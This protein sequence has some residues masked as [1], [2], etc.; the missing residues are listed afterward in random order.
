VIHVIEGSSADEVWA[1][2]LRLVRSPAASLVDG[3][4]GEAI[5]LSHAAIEIA[6][7]RRRWVVGRV[8]AINPAF[9]IAEIIW[10]VRGRSD[11]AFLTHWNR[12]LHHFVGE[13][14][15]LHGAYGSRLRS[16]FPVDQ[17][18]RAAEVLGANPTSRQVV[19]Q[20]WDPGIDL[21][22]PGGAPASED[23]PCNISSMLKV[24]SEKLYWTQTIRSNDVF[25][26]LP[27]NVVLFT[28]LQEIL[29]G[30]IGVDI[31][32]YTQWSDSLHLYVRD[33]GKADHVELSYDPSA[34]DIRLRRSDSDVVFAR[35]ERLCVELTDRVL[36]ELSLISLLKGL[37]MPQSYVSLASALCAEEAR[38]RGWKDAQALALSLCKTASLKTV[39]LRWFAERQDHHRGAGEG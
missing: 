32:T 8:P 5:E 16:H 28:T 3:R 29:A 33:A 24:R 13:Q 26:G 4:G 1:R 14:E 19:L 37:D 18:L 25:L 27:Y 30:W 20:I 11:A 7:P 31:G 38:K 10:V 15:H 6:D 35:L 34:E 22:L 17:L 39:L 9:A 21:P 12:S 36:D 2:A 23:I